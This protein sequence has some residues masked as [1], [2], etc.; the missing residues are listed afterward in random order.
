ML[1]T[2]KDVTIYKVTY[3]ISGGRPKEA[4]IVSGH[5]LEKKEAQD[6]IH[7][8]LRA[9]G[10]IRYADKIT[11]EEIESNKL[12]IDGCDIELAEDR[13]VGDLIIQ[14]STNKQ[15]KILDIEYSKLREA[16]FELVEIHCDEYLD[17]LLVKSTF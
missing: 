16:V 12:K 9:E 15:W 4:R 7:E 2:T 8:W 3:R 6:M 1:I 13:K 5:P 17:P 11:V 14:R 10:E